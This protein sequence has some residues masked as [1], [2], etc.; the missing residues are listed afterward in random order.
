[1]TRLPTAK[2]R[3][4]KL[5]RGSYCRVNEN[6]FV[7]LKEPKFGIVVDSIREKLTNAAV[8]SVVLVDGELLLVSH[9]DPCQKN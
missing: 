6:S 1:M 2:H 8:Y 5:N 9:K 3:L 4:L 7:V